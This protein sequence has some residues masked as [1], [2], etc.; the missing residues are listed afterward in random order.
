MRLLGGWMRF[1]LV[2]KLNEV[3]LKLNSQNTSYG[4]IPFLP[5][6]ILAIAKLSELATIGLNNV[7]QGIF[8]YQL[9][10]TSYSDIQSPLYIIEYNLLWY[11]PHLPCV[12]AVSA[13]PPNST[14]CVPSRHSP[15][16]AR[17]PP[18]V[19][20]EQCAKAFFRSPLCCPL[21]IGIFSNSGFCV[22]FWEGGGSNFVKK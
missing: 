18:A 13:P 10:N 2:L 7:I 17:F 19:Q 8:P 5:S 3:Q 12:R 4:S 21:E 16:A 20:F 11:C 14:Q 1:S 15:L 22:R 6:G 9:K